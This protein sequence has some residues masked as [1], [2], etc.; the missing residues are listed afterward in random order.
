[1]KW[2][3]FFIMANTDPFAVKTLKFDT[4][5]ECINYVNDPILLVSVPRLPTPLTIALHLVNNDECI[6]T[7]TITT[8]SE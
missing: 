5:N 2:L 6:L 7:L 4:M 8:I 1:M 3:I